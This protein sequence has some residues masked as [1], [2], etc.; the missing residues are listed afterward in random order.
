MAPLRF[1]CGTWS[2]AGLMPTTRAKLEKRDE[3]STVFSLY[4]CG[5]FAQDTPHWDKTS[6]CIRHRSATNVETVAHTSPIDAKL[7][8]RGF[9]ATSITA[10]KWSRSC[11][12]NGRSCITSAGK[13]SSTKGRSDHHTLRCYHYGYYGVVTQLLL[14][15]PPPLPIIVTISRLTTK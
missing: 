4:A 13:P 9:R 15:P 2:I 10:P 3:R 12:T 1:P 14:L 5:R 11:A 7:R 8:R 6:Q